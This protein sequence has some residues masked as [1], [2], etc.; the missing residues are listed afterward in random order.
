MFEEAVAINL[1]GAYR[2]ANAARGLLASSEIEG[3]ASVV[4]LASMASFF[5]IEMVPGYGA[6]KAGVVQLTKTHAVSWAKRGIRGTPSRPGS[7]RPA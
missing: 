4:N 5:G 3:G 1:F 7:W 2:M 6:A